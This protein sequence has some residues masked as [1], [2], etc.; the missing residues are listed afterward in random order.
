[1]FARISVCAL[2]CFEYTIF[3]QCVKTVFLPNDGACCF[4]FYLAKSNAD[5]MTVG[6]GNHSKS[7]V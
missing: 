1:M 6:S 2:M 4:Y 7:Y 5:R 3:L